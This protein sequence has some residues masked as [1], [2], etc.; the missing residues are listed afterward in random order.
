MGYHIVGNFTGAK[1]CGN[2]SRPFRRNFCGF[3]FC[4]TN[5]SCFDNNPT[6]DD[7][8]PHTNWI[9]ASEEASM[10]NNALSFLFFFCVEAF[11]ITKVLYSLDIIPPSPLCWWDLT[12]SLGEGGGAYNWIMVI[13]LVYT[14]PFLAVERMRKTTMAELSITVSCSL[15]WSSLWLSSAGQRIMKLSMKAQSVCSQKTRCIF[16]HHHE[17]AAT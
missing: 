2:A 10:C 4:K 16:L 15:Q 3:Y 7:H 17:P 1:F 11:A 8:A 12:T 13:S 5:A 14:L 6:V 9:N